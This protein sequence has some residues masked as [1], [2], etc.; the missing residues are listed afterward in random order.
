M[1]ITAYAIIRAPAGWCCSIKRTLDNSSGTSATV[2]HVEENRSLGTV[3]F[4][5][6]AFHTEIAADDTDFFVLQLKN[7]MRT[8]FEAHAAVIAFFLDQLKTHHLRIIP[9]SV[10][11]IMFLTKNY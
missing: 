11:R 5:S 10:H 3:H 6:A 8:H 9:Q 1:S 4:T 2:S 7:F